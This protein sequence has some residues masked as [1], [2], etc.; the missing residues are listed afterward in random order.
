MVMQTERTICSTP[1]CDRVA[2]SGSSRNECGTH[3]RDRLR[4]LR[5]DSSVTETR[6]KVDY[7]DSQAAD[8]AFGADRVE[9]YWDETKGYGAV[10]EVDG[11]LMHRDYKGEVHEA[12]DAVLET[13]FGGEDAADVV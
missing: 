10:H 2:D 9:H 3:Y 5:L 4:S 7:F 13:V 8:E 12:T 11:K 6:T 1:G